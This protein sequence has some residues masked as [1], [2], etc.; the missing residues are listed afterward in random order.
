[1]WA[2]KHTPVGSGGG[3]SAGIITS[4]TSVAAPIATGA[5][6]SSFLPRR[7]AGLVSFILR[8]GTGQYEVS[9][10]LITFCAHIVI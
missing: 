1:L 7:L 8:F 10:A 9:Q 5:I 4:A 2:F 6:K 3:A